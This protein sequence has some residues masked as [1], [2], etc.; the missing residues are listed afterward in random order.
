MC[1][2]IVKKT[3][4]SIIATLILTIFPLSMQADVKNNWEQSEQ[5][6]TEVTMKDYRGGYLLNAEHGVISI[7]SG[8]QQ[9]WSIGYSLSK[10]YF[11]WYL[12]I[13]EAVILTLKSLYPFWKCYE[14]Y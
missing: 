1:L 4:S 5:E 7:H 11:H 9:L 13:Y 8:G 14:S 2:K 6:K 10:F 12:F 3:I